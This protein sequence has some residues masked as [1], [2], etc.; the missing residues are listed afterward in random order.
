VIYVLHDATKPELYGGLPS[1]PTIPLA[2]RLWKKPLK[3]LGNLAIVG[4]LV[5]LFVHYLRFG[6]K[7][8]EE[9]DITG[10]QS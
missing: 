8:R 10:V 2:V 9:E 7:A 3:W 1:S 5:G 4:G 6:P